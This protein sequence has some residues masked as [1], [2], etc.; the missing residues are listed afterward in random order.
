MPEVLVV[1]KTDEADPY[2]MLVRMAAI[3]IIFQLVPVI[4]R[5]SVRI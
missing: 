4:C 2:I 3:I 5:T 1:H